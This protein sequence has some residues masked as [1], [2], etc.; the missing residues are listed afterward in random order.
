M[1]NTRLNSLVGALG[2]RLTRS[3]QNPWRRLAA[4]LIS[5]LFGNFLATALSTISG[6][7]ADLDV[8]VSVF[9]VLLV[10]IVSWLTYGSPFRRSP[11]PSSPRPLLIELLNGLKLGMI[12]G[13]FVEAFKLG[14]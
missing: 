1:Q 12:Y 2:D 6:Q 13:L 7:A 14:S 8:S 4:L 5:V 10:E 11:N 3:L 9:L